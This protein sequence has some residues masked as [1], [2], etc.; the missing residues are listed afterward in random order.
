MWP[1]ADSFSLGG[2]QGHGIKGGS[3]EVHPEL[4]HAAGRFGCRAR[5]VGHLP[6]RS[7][8]ELVPLERV[9]VSLS[10][11]L[12]TVARGIQPFH[13]ELSFGGI[14]VEREV[15]AAF[16]V[17]VFEGDLPYFIL[18]IQP[19]PAIKWDY[20]HPNARA[21]CIEISIPAG[22]STVVEVSG[23][24]MVHDRSTGPQAASIEGL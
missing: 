12:D 15:A 5:W 21:L 10:E 4:C 11:A 19:H 6:P 24:F 13:L 8:L 14:G 16:D 7:V 9:P 18:R 22:I 2:M 1:G 20:P 3:L 23:L 17:P